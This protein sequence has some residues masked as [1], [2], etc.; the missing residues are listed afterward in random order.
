MIQFSKNL[1]TD[2]F[3][4]AI[5]EN[6]DAIY[7]CDEVGVCKPHPAPYQLVLNQSKSEPQN[8]YMVAAHAW[9]IMGAQAVGM[10]T[11]WISRMEKRWPFPGNPPGKVVNNLEEMR[12]NFS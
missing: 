10:K 5:L 7:S 6:F 12:N 2:F 11:L 8:S 1:P 4:E 9:D 3:D